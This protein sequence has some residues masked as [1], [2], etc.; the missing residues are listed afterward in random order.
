LPEPAATWLTDL[1]QGLA[2]QPLAALSVADGALL[3]AQACHPEGVDGEELTALLQKRFD[4]FHGVSAAL[5]DLTALAH[6]DGTWPGSLR[7]GG[8]FQA[9]QLLLGDLDQELPGHG[10]SPP[11]QP[12]TPP[13][14]LVTSS[15]EG[16]LS[17]LLEERVIA[18]GTLPMRLAFIA[19]SGAVTARISAS[20]LA[21]EAKLRRQLDPVLPFAR[22]SLQVLP[23]GRST[24][25][26]ADPAAAAPSLFRLPL[27]LG[28]RLWCADNLGLLPQ[29]GNGGAPLLAWTLLH[30]LLPKGAPHRR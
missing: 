4:Q 5:A 16:Q 15:L 30:R 9:G 14:R 24:V 18:G 26:L 21:D 10:V 11:R 13:Q 23:S 27:H 3:W 20:V 6:R 29:F 22:Y 25:R 12:L 17:P 2:M 7:A 19:S 28:N 1:F 8:D